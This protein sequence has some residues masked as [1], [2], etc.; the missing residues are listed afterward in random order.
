MTTIGGL[1]IEIIGPGAAQTSIDSVIAAQAALPQ[2]FELL[3]Q[4]KFR[5]LIL[6]D[7]VAD[8]IVVKSL[9]CATT[10]ARVLECLQVLPSD[11]YLEFAAAIVAE[12]QNEIALNI[13]HGWPILSVGVVAV[14][15]VA[16]AGGVASLS[17]ES[18]ALCTT[19]D[20]RLD[21]TAIRA[22]SVRDCPHAQQEA[23]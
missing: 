8:L 4:G 20:H 21:D 23:A 2:V 19:C 13:L 10:G 18:P 6:G 9:D 1:R 12:G 15:T 16:D 5:S 3:L 14:P 17:G 11:R 22:C 7:D